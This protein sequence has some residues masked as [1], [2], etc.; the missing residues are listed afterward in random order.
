MS[1]LC[2]NTYFNVFLLDLTWG[3]QIKL[4]LTDLFI[5]VHFFIVIL[6]KKPFRLEATCRVYLFV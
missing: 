2:E 3:V 4:D 1:F 5:C 6:K